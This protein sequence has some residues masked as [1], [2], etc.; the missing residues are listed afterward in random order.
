MTTFANAVQTQV[1]RTANNMKAVKGTGNACVDLF[2]K[3]GASRGSNILTSFVPAMQENNE[4]A[5][6]IA[7]WGRDVRGGAGERDLFK[8]VLQY[9]ELNDALAARRL[10]KLVPEIGRWDDLLVFRTESIRADAFAMIANALRNGNGLCAKWMPRKGAIAV[11]LRDFMKMSP[12]QYRKTLVGLTNVVETQMCAK[13]WKNINFN[14]VPSL[15]SIRYKSAFLRNAEAEYEAWADK[16]ATGADGAKVNAGAVFPY[17]VL[18]GFIGTRALLD[19]FGAAVVG[20]A[21]AQWAALENF[22]GEASILPMVDV[23]GSMIHPITGSDTTAM[24]VAV[25]LGLYL[26]EKNRG[27]FQDLVLTFSGSPELLKLSGNVLDKIPQILAG[28]WGMNTNLHAAF[29]L[30]LQTAVNG[31]VAQADMPKT[32]LILSDMQFDQCVEFDDTALE[33]IQRKYEAAGYEV[34]NVV[35][36][37][38]VSYGN[39]PAKAD[40]K[41][42]ALVSGFSPAIVRS[43]LANDNLTPEAVMLRT[44]MVP[45]YD[46]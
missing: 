11:A 36:W 20:V 19:S 7:A 5:L 18:H 15:A 44:V 46:M 9:L 35:F 27:A 32:V 41:N 26:A 23:S 8:Q 40:T 29:E 39:V 4:V 42:V 28:D 2:Y 30:I 12:K 34:P 6:R 17:Q 43:V 31:K 33:M 38:L 45:R 14:H 3:F 16:L 10:M 1:A 22:V 13:D 25:S 37:N 21:L 24:D